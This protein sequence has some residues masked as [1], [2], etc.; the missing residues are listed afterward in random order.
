VFGEQLLEYQSHKNL[1]RRKIYAFS[2]TSGAIITAGLIVFAIIWSLFHLEDLP[3]PAVAV[4]FFAAAPPP[5]PPPPPA[6]KKKE[7]PKPKPVVQP[8]LQQIKSALVQPK[9]REVEQEPDRDDD[10]GV[11]GGVEGGVPGGVIGGVL[12]GEKDKA[13]PPPPPK[14]EPPPP[15]KIVPPTVLETQRISGAIPPLPPTV[16]EQAFNALGNQPGTL[17]AMFKVCIGMDGSIAQVNLIK[18][19]GSA[20]LD[21][22]IKA[23]LR[24][25][26]YRPYLINGKP[27]P[28]CGT[29]VFNVRLE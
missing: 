9:V 28:I 24:T 15:P 20:A 25:W 11:E 8:T 29:K 2:F 1:R 21:E 13:P 19:S 27:T 23:N 18:P 6:K 7:Q 5:P 10:Q 12:G 26:R 4:T 17:V 3:A 22:F 16:K 14:P